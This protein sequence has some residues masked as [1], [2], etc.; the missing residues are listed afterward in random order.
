VLALG[1]A[2]SASDIRVVHV[3]DNEGK[4]ILTPTSH[5]LKFYGYLRIGASVYKRG[6]LIKTRR[7][8]PLFG[9]LQMVAAGKGATYVVFAREPTGIYRPD[10]WFAEE[11]GKVSWPEQKDWDKEWDKQSAKEQWPTAESFE[12]QFKSATQDSWMPILGQLKTAGCRSQ[13][14]WCKP[15]TV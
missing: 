10:T 8:P 4:N 2:L 15:T 13:L 1:A 7:L 12:V 6:A 5:E 11:L 14:L 3:L 9:R